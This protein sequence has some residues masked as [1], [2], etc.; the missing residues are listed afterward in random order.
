MKTK[1]VC[2]RFSAAFVFAWDAFHIWGVGS[3]TVNTTVDL[4]GGYLL[5]GIALGGQRLWLMVGCEV[6]L[7]S[8]AEIW[9]WVAVSWYIVF[10]AE[11]ETWSIDAQ[12]DRISLVPLPSSYHVLSSSS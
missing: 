5:F 9:S 1:Q 4:A 7:N 11:K 2:P 6:G 3:K 12:M 8:L 10:K